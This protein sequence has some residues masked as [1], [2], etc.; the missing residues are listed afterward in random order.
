MPDADLCFQI[1]GKPV[2]D[3]FNDPVLPERSMNKDPQCYNKEQQGEKEPKQ[4]FFK[5]LQAQQ[6]KWQK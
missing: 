1:P 5:S 2:G 6:I 3:F 4:Y